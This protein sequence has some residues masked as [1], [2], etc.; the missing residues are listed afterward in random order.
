[1]ATSTV[2]TSLTI[3]STVHDSWTESF[4]G[5]RHLIYVVLPKPGVRM[6][7]EIRTLCQ[8]A[9]IGSN[10]LMEVALY[11]LLHPFATTPAPLSA[12]TESLLSEASYW[13][14]LTRWVPAASGKPIDLKKEP[15]LSTDRLRRRR[16][17]TVHKSSATANV[18]MAR[19]A[20]ASATE[21]VK[22]LHKHFGQPLPYESFL[23]TWPLP[24]E[25]PFSSVTFP[26]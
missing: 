3:T 6:S 22:A 18:P 23:K 7:P 1:M 20:F 10:H 9:L 4:V 26:T 13:H 25:R 24:I 11:K 5:T 19:S 2:I 15:F 8:L 12:L 16:N 21:G 17:D 14:M